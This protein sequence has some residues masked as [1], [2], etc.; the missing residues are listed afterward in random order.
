[1]DLLKRF[2]AQSNQIVENISHK[3]RDGHKNF[4]ALEFANLI[5][6][7]VKC[8]KQQMKQEIQ[9]CYMNMLGAMSAS[10]A[11]QFV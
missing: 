2:E 10:V 3:R 6:L 9:E 4:M 5:E 1:M 7:F 8:S 11:D